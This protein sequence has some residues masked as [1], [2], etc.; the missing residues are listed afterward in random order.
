MSDED[1]RPISQLFVKKSK[2]PS[3]NEDDQPIG[4][5]FLKKSGNLKDDRGKPSRSPKKPYSNMAFARAKDPKRNVLQGKMLELT[6]DHETGQVFIENKMLPANFVGNNL[7]LQVEQD[8]AC[9]CCL[10]KTRLLL[11]SFPMQVFFTCTAI[12]TTN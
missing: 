1:D 8:I 5:L 10:K 9:P 3:L 12:S 11:G 7:V 6:G 2:K 4:Q